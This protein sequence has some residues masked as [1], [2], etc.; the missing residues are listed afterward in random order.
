MPSSTTV[1]H[2][3]EKIIFTEATHEYV[4]SKSRK[5]TSV[6]TL[7]GMGF[8][9]FDTIGIAKAKAAREG[10]NYKDLVNLWAETGKKAANSGTRLHEN[11]ENQILGRVEMMHDPVTPEEALK[12]KFARDEVSR[13]LKDPEN[14]KFEPEK[15]IFSPKYLLAGS[16]DLLVTRA[17]GS[18]VIYD[19]KNVKEIKETAFRDKKGILDSTKDIQDSN[20]WHYALQLQLYEIILK[21]NSYIPKDAK[22]TRVINAFEVSGFHRYE[23]PNLLKE[24]CG[25]I[26]WN[27]I[28][29]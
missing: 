22:V 5:Y 29:K 13:L 14:V 17:D 16:V 12:F 19:W 7:V 15:L 10:T 20:Y 28:Q 23:M 18:Y 8:E 24:A 11:C 6:T 4:D 1:Q 3:G 27:N 26:K 21:V 2:N 25:L 9:K